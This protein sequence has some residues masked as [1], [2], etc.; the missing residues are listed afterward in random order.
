MK[1]YIKEIIILLIQI[2]MFYIYPLL[3]RMNDP[4]GLVLIILLI[5]FILST[6]VGVISKGKIKYLYPII[7][8]I[9]F[10]PTIFIYYNESALIHSL[11]YLTISYIGIFIGIFLSKL[12]NIL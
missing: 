3:D 1:K 7:I 12:K 5:T 9:L 11:W 10:I 6:I 4:F 8:S 2:F